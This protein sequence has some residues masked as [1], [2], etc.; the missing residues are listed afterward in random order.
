MNFKDYMLTD[1]YRCCVLGDSV[2]NVDTTFDLV[3]GLWLTDT[4][5][6]CLVLL[7]EFDKHPEFPGP[8]MWHF[9][10]DEKEF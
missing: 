10:K 7:D 9:R 6:K 3:P 8:S 5:Y 2:L 4:S 1:I